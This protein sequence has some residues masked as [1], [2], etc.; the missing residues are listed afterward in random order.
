MCNG[1]SDLKVR[2]DCLYNVSDHYPISITSDTN[3]LCNTS[4]KLAVGRKVLL[5]SK[6]DEWQK[7]YYRS[8]LDKLLDINLSNYTVNDEFIVEQFNSI[9]VNAVHSAAISC[10]PTGYFRHF[11][12]PYWKSNQLNLYHDQQRHGRNQWI[13]KVAYMIKT[14]FTLLSIKHERPSFESGNVE[15]NGVGEKKVC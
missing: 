5:W 1:C 7:Q 8:E 10:I 3:L 12:K 11:L 14:I 9:L 2:N 15:L 4:N 6:S 13:S